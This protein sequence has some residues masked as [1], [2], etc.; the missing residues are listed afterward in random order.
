MNMFEA[1]KPE[2][3][4]SIVAIRKAVGILGRFTDIE[5]EQLWKAFSRTY[6]AGYLGTDEETLKNFATWLEQ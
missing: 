3:P 4:E 5:V 6:A 2:S 1:L